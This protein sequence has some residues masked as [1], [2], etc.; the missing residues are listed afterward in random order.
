MELNCD[1][2]CIFLS[3]LFLTNMQ[4]EEVTMKSVSTKVVIFASKICL[5]YSASRAPA[6]TLLGELITALPRPP[7]WWGGAPCTAPPQKPH[8]HQPFRPRHRCA[9]NCEIL[10]MPLIQMSWPAVQHTGVN[11]VAISV[12]NS[13][14]NR[15]FFIDCLCQGTLKTHVI[16]EFTGQPIFL[17]FDPVHAIKNVCNNLE[18]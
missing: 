14:T 6:W 8:P 12:D 18:S 17:I 15:K 10:A 11:V 3:V 7:S 9:P 1:V 16:D 2:F 13:A 5:N 4:Q